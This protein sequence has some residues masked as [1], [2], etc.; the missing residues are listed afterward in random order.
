MPKYLASGTFTPD[1][2]KGFR[3]QGAAARIEMNRRAVASLGGTVEAYY[4]AFGSYDLIAV[5]DLPD[6]EAAAAASIAVNEAGAVKVTVTKLLTAAQVD[7]ALTRT[8]AYQPPG[9]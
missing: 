2:L 7:D 9:Q 3:T 5:I 8:V 4:F 6:D 1:G